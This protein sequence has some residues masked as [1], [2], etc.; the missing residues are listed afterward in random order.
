MAESVA[1]LLEGQRVLII[2][3]G[4]D[5]NGRQLGATINAGRRWPVVVRVNKFYGDPRDVGARMD[6]LVTRYADWVGKYFPGPVIGC[7]KVFLN[8]FFGFSQQ[9]YQTT[10]AEINHP[11]ASA[12]LLACAWALNRGAH[13]VTILGFGHHPVTG[14]AKIKTYPDRTPDPN[15]LYNWPAEH[16]WLEANVILL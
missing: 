2:G 3:S 12:G 13:S 16:R 5:L 14:W 1:Q 11:H 9:E 7:P 8:E 10:L 15:P 4:S 6:A